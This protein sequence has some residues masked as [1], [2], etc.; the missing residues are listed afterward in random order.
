[1]LG[2]KTLAFD[3]V[4]GGT[5]PGRAASITVVCKAFPQSSSIQG[6]IFGWRRG[7]RPTQLRLRTQ[8]SECGS[9]DELR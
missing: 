4:P 9:S 1:M 6:V 3:M 2:A 8:M 5:R 7:A